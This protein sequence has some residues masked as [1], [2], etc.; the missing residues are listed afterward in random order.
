MIADLLYDIPILAQNR[1]LIGE[2][3]VKHIEMSVIRV[4]PFY[5]II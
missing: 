3:S 2:T 1:G 5:N 4:K